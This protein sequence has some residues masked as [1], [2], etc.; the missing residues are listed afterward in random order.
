[1]IEVAALVGLLGVALAVFVVLALGWL[2]VKLVFKI[3]LFPIT[4]A[5]GAV[6]IAVLVVLAVLTLVAAP[7]VLLVGAVL[8]IPFL[9][10]AAVVGLGVAVFAIAT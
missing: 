9:L 10:L 3:V 8:L 2:V 4:L 5:L 1:M 7:V 6:K